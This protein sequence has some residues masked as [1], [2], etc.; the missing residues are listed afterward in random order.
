MHRRTI[1]DQENPANKPENS[2]YAR[3]IKCQRPAVIEFEITQEPR[4]WHDDHRPELSTLNEKNLD[5]RH[6]VE[7]GSVTRK[8]RTC[9]DKGAYSRPFKCRDP[10]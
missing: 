3:D 6:I 1:I 2:D 5:I 7:R 10:F 4:Q 8:M 9:Q